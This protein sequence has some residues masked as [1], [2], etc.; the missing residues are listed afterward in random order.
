LGLY[1][2]KTPPVQ[3]EYAFDYVPG[4]VRMPK[5]AAYYQATF[6]QYNDMF[7][8]SAQAIGCVYLWLHFF[9]LDTQGELGMSLLRRAYA[10]RRGSHGHW[11]I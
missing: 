2:T 10:L 3:L 7:K 8:D 1:R 6:A 9:Y 5:A 11:R 4:V